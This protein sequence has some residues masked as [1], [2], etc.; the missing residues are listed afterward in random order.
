MKERLIKRFNKPFPVKN[1]LIPLI[2]DKKEVKIADVGSGPVSRIGELL[3]GVKI[4]IYPSDKKDYT[5]ITW[6]GLGIKPR[7][8]IEVQNMEE[9][10]Y[11][12]DFF[13]IVHC[14]N[15]LDHTRDAVAAI[16][17]MIRIVKPEGWVYIDC[18][19][20]QLSV[21][22]GRHFWDAKEDGTFINKNDSFSLKDMGFSIEFL[23]TPGERRYKRIIAIYKKL[24][25]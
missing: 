17:E 7:F 11:S 1:R 24:N 3:P 25:I 14:G 4:E 10:S 12:D 6:N 13:D 16:K 19:L 21:S 20:D 22:G 18:S 23:D 15:A 9:F 2:G 5:K 8:P